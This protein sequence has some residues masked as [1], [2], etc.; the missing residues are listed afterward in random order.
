MNQRYLQNHCLTVEVL[1]RGVAWLD[2][3]TLESLSEVSVFVRAIKKRQGHNIS[4]PEEIALAYAPQLVR[5][6]N[7]MPSTEYG[8]Y[9]RMLAKEPD[10]P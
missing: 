8:S 2:I 9:L 5:V 3:G 6:A 1:G 10:A 4:R 7:G